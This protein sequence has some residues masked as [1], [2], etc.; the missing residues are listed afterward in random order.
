MTYK[1][2]S[3]LLLLS[4]LSG[5]TIWRHAQPDGAPWLDQHRSFDHVP[6]AVPKKEPPSKYGNP[7]SFQVK[8]KRYHVFHTNYGYKAQGLASWYGTHFHGRKTSSG[9]PYD[10]YAMT[11]A[12]PHLPIP[13]YAK[14]RHT[15][16]GKEVIVKINDRG[17]FHGGRIIDLSFAAAK[18]LG[19]FGHGTG[20]VTVTAVPP[21]QTR[22]LADHSTP[23]SA[24]MFK[25]KPTNTTLKVQHQK[26]GLKLHKKQVPQ[27]RKKMI[28]KANG[29]P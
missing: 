20:H 12:H 23:T 28:A 5:C 22:T 14:V 17:P 9:E 24:A 19:I 8:G 25:P 18:K 10:M 13:S 27:H 21:Y 2:W 6:N 7:A 26:P 3:F 4:C 11:A 16:T 15:K 1:K 29:K